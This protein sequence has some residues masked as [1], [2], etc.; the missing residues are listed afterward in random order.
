MNIYVIFN[1]IT[2]EPIGYTDDISG[3]PPLTLWKMFNVEGNEFN[4]ER[5]KYLGKYT[6]GDLVDLIKAKKS[7]VYEKDVDEKYENMFYRK[8]SDRD[9]LMALFEDDAELELMRHFRG[10]IK[11]KKANEMNMYKT[12]DSYIFVTREEQPKQEQETFKK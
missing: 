10:K 11:D 12:N 1:K 3:Y 5:Y 6:D 7:V 9:I 8:Y 4:I 2:H